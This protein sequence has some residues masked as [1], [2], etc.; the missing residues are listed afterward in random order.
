M[1][2]VRTLYQ[3]P[4]NTLY[5][6]LCTM[7]VEDAGWMVVAAKEIAPK[8]GIITFCKRNRMYVARMWSK[9]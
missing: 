4:K 9:S 6:T 2:R 1:T 7:T 5:Y 8:V 3:S